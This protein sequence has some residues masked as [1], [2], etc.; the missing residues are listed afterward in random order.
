MVRSG[1]A[2]GSRLVGLGSDRV[3]LRVSTHQADA[4]ADAL[5]H[6]RAAKA[7]VVRQGDTVEVTSERAVLHEAT[8]V[9]IDEAGERL[10][11]MCTSLLRGE[12]TTAEV[13]AELESLRGLL[14]LL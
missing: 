14:D 5:T 11:R 12:A 3:T 2:I 4:L 13:R 6:L 1:C 10:S 8:L 7:E 9:A